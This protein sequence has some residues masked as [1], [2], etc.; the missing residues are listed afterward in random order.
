MSYNV[1][2]I[3][4]NERTKTKNKGEQVYAEA[5]DKYIILRS[6]ALHYLQ[7]AHRKRY[8]SRPLRQSRLVTIGQPDDRQNNNQ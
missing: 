5:V 2:S 7:A 3:P 1:T 6:R 4:S 8:F